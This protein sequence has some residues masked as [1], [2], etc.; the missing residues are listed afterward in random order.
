[1]APMH[2]LMLAF[3]EHL[4]PVA[5]AVLVN[6]A[7]MSHP[8]PLHPRSVQVLMCFGHS[9]GVMMHFKVLL[10]PA[11]ILYCWEVYTCILQVVMGWGVDRGLAIALLVSACVQAAAILAAAVSESLK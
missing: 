10:W 6:H 1:M 11:L 5:P 7:L 4:E 9:R 2:G 3:A 8:D